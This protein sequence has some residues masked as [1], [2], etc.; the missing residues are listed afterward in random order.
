MGLKEILE[1]LRSGEIKK[2]W[3]SLYQH[4]RGVLFLGVFFVLFVLMLLLSSGNDKAVSTD[5]NVPVEEGSDVNMVGVESSMDP[6]D[7][8]TYKIQEKLEAIARDL[9]Q[10]INSQDSKNKD[11]IEQLKQELEL[12]RQELNRHKM[13][14]DEKELEAN[15]R[16]VSDVSLEEQG[17]AVARLSLGSFS[18]KYSTAKKN[19]KEYVTSGSFAR[20]VLLTGVVVGTGSDTQSNPEPVMLRLTD[21][22]IFSKGLRTDQIK[23]AILIGDCSGDL[24]SERA[25]CRLQTLS[26]ENYKGEIIEKPVQGWVVGEDGRNGIKGKVIDK[27]SD[28]IRMS[29]FNGLLGGMSKFFE[30][31]ATS[32]VFPLSPIT[33][34]QNALS[35]MAAIKGGA[36]SGAGDAF[37]KMA[38]FLMERFNSMSPQI[39]IASGREVDVVFR[40]GVDLR[41]SETDDDKSVSQVA[42]GNMASNVGI[43]ATDNNGNSGL[44]YEAYGR[45][46]FD[47]AIQNMNNNIGGNVSGNAGGF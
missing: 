29:M 10:R 28:L 13:R 45:N 9:E 22:G 43:Y 32:G 37:A 41:G 34:Q 1:L 20:A 16:I 6:R 3:F 27:S 14:I 35:G 2:A 36:A 39:V 25:K 15:V 5:I 23:E 12:V 19:T 8:W 24:S 7:L 11:V 33:G 40:N 46:S 4:H 18:R 17:G 21:A 38:D 47:E 44:Q 26:L 31:Q 42:S 30:N